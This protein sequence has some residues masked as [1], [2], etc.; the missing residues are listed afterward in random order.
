MCHVDRVGLT[1]GLTLRS[2]GLTFDEQN[3][4]RISALLAQNIALDE[5][6]QYNR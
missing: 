1:T 2:D 5:R 3:G 4:F 6:V